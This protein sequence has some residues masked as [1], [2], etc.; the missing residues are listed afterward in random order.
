MDAMR[1]GR[2]L[3]AGLVFL[4]LLGGGP[5]CAQFHGRGAEV[6]VVSPV[7]IVSEPS[8]MH[9]ISIEVTNR[10]NR[11]ERFREDV[12]LPKGWSM[13]IPMTSFVLPPQ[14]STARLLSFQIPINAAEGRAKIQYSVQSDRD[15]SIRG[16]MEYEVVVLAVA[17]TDL[18]VENPPASLMAGE[19]YEFSARLVN[20]GNIPRTFLIRAKNTDP[21]S[22]ALA[23]P[24][25]VSLKPGEG[26]AISVSGK[27]DPGFRGTVTVIQITAEIEKD[28]KRGGRLHCCPP[29]GRARPLQKPE[30]YHILPS[31]FAVSAARTAG[32][33]TKPSFEWKGRVPSTKRE[34]SNFPFPS[35]ARCGRFLLLQQDRRILDEL[36]EPFSRDPDGGP[37]LRRLPRPFIPPTEGGLGWISSP[38]PEGTCP[39]ACST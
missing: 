13:V 25:E 17:K 27:I 8:R 5:S 1:V 32:G 31:T 2:G 14:A 9:T 39:Q 21:N 29:G 18:M 33:D 36:F 10:T 37:A 6:R 19:E 16:S 24:S 20:S 12:I 34:N 11:Q 26:A 28:G 3:S 35:G 22:P 38:W 4:L 23:A 30:P 7:Q 15:P